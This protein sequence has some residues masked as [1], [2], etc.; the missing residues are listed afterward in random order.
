MR[1]GGFKTVERVDRT[2]Q[3]QVYRER[4]K[5]LRESTVQQRLFPVSEST[6]P[7]NEEAF[8]ERVVTVPI[9][10]K[11]GRSNAKQTNNKRK[12][13]AANKKLRDHLFKQACQ[14]WQEELA[15][16]DA[17]VADGVFYK[18]KSAETICAAINSTDA[19]QA[20]NIMLV[21]KS[22]RTAVKQGRHALQKP[23]EKGTIPL[24]CYEALCG[25]VSSYTVLAQ[26]GGTMAASVIR[27]VLV[28]KVNAC[29][30]KKEGL[31][32][33]HNRK[34][35]DR[36]QADIADDLDVGKANRVE[37]RRNKWS[38]HSNIN[39]WFSSFKTWLI[40]MGFAVAAS[41]DDRSGELRWVSDDQ[42]ARIG[43]MDETGLVLDNT[44]NGKGGR[45]AVAF[46]NPRIAK[47]PTQA[48]HKSSY[49]CTMVSG[50]FANGDKFPE[51]FQIPS[52]AQLENQGFGMDFI[53]D[54]DHEDSR[55]TLDLTDHS[56]SVTE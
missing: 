26:Q 29:I 30:N 46:Y 3:R 45:P 13:K 50:G 4:D 8:K 5:L 15:Q 9:K 25:A 53:E 48:A 14:E 24:N 31:R 20:N 47:A 39:L 43:N 17:A 49:H 19:A 28:K 16:K 12:V 36:V 34:L 2:Y 33:R 40:D 18:A 54:N 41:P 6:Q 37:Q 11:Q 38:T 10:Q 23:G 44:E 1:I 35:F 51:H 21:S 55:S 56:S 32:K 27:P 52:D 7:E 22:V 42:G